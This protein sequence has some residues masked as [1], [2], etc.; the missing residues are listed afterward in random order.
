MIRAT[1]DPGSPY[2][3]VFAT[4]G[5]GIVVQWR[6]AQGGTSSQ[7]SIA[8]TLPVYLQITATG[9]AFSAATSA[10]GVTWTPIPKSSVTLANLAGAALAGLA[11]SSHNTGQLSTVTYGSVVVA[12]S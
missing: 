8:G 11:V 7:I 6:S 2:Y 10:D 9:S 4:P 3:A 1:T 12:P 5:N